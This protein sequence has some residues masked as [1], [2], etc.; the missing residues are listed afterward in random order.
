MWNVEREPSVPMSY[1]AA[2]V[3]PWITFTVSVLTSST[4]AT[5]CAI[6]VSEP[7]PMSIVLQ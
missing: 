3:S 2:S 7:C 1:G 5:I 6:A 4:S